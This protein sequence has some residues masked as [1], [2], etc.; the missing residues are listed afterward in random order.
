LPRQVDGLP[1]EPEKLAA[2]HPGRSREAPERCKAVMLNVAEESA[3]LGRGP[4]HHAGVRYARGSNPGCGVAG[5]I[6]MP[7]ETRR[8]WVVRRE[9]LEQAL[10]TLEAQV[11]Q[12]TGRMDS[13]DDALALDAAI[14][15]LGLEKLVARRTAALDLHIKNQP[16]IF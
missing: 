3:Q 5:E 13:G 4:R 7:Q 12:E 1:L 14:R 8:A 6:L 16:R 11:R 10:R 15:V 2:T 9:Q